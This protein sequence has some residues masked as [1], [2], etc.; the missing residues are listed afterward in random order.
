MTLAQTYDKSYEV[1]INSSVDTVN[2]NDTL[3]NWTSYFPIPLNLA[4]G[5]YKMAVKSAAVCNTIDQFH[6][7]NNKFKINSTVYTV[8][9][10]RIYS[11][12]STLCTYLSNLVSG[13][14]IDFS[15]DPDTQRVRVVNNSGTTKTLDLTGDYLR[16]W[17]KL[18]F[19]YSSTTTPN[20]I[21]LN[22]I[23]L[24]H[25]AT[26]IP[27]QKVYITCDEILPNSSYPTNSNRGIL[28]DISL[29]AG[30]GIYTAYQ[31]STFYFHELR[32]N[33]SLSHLSF[34]LLDDKY[35]VIKDLKGGSINLSLIIKK[36]D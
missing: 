5:K 12:T 16:F 15:L 6:D 22:D 34:Q 32:V 9:T 4:Y 31:P 30:Y 29:Q 11:T 3:S 2:L 17:K 21:D 25:I 28:T 20:T 23:L 13:E 14:S 8:E 35:E 33:N 24:Q 36:V 10:D 1:Y 7:R 18:G 26:L 19:R 27:T